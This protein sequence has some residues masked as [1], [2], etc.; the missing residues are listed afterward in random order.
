MKHLKIEINY[1]FCQ[2]DEL[3][4]EEADLIRRAIAL[5]IMPMQNTVISVSEQ[6]SVWQTAQ[7]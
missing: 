2:L 5:P 1:D 6:L 7:L 4:V 3:N